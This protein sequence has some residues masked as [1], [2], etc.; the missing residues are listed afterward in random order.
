MRRLLLIAAILGTNLGSVAYADCT[1]ENVAGTYGYV[2]FG[3]IGTSNPF[4]LPP[5]SYSSVG[6]LAFDGK[7]NV[8]ITDTARIGDFFL[9]PDA[10]YPS[11]YTV[12]AQC[13]GTLTVS[14]FVNIGIPGPHY[15]LVFVDNLKGVRT[16]SLIPGWIVNYL[17]TTRI[18]SGSQEE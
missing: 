18:K 7:G 10:K 2:G 16:I 13:V 17:T 14:H 3:T 4:G 11:T 8:L 12:N 15:K 6:T 1:T 5:G 9:T